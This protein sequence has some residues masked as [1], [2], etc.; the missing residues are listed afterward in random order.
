MDFVSIRNGH[1]WE[2]RF[3]KVLEAQNG[4]CS[5]LSQKWSQRGF[6]IRKMKGLRAWVPVEPKMVPDEVLDKEN[7]RFESMCAD[8]ALELRNC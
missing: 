8:R 4:P 2:E 1:H 6:W 3:W 7:E 5:W